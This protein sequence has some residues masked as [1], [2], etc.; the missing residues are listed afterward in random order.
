MTLTI[1]AMDNE[2]NFIRF[3]D[4]ELCEISETHEKGGL[5]TLHL[6]YLFQD[7]NEDRELFQIGNKIWIANDPNLTDCLY[8]I[9]TEVEQDVYKENSFTLD[10]EEVL[11]ELNYAPLFSQTELGL[12]D[13]YNNPVFKLST[14]NG[15]QEVTINW[16]ALNHFFGEYFN[17][18]IVQKC[19]SEYAGKCAINGTMNRMSLLRY[20]EN[21]TGNVFVTRYEKDILTNTIHRYLDFLNPINSNK[22]WEYNIEYDFVSTDTSAEG[23]FDDNDNPTTD[24]Y[25]D[26]EDEDDIVTFDK[27]GHLTNIDPEGISFRFTDNGKI[28]TADDG[29]SLE[30]FSSELGFENNNQHAII[31]ICKTGKTLGLDINEKSYAV[32]DNSQGEPEG[33]GF[34]IVA[35]DPDEPK[36]TLLPD[37]CCFEIYDINQDK[38]I[39]STIINSQIGVVHEEVIDF[40]FNMENVVYNINETDSFNAISPVLSLSEN[41]LSRT[42]LGSLITDWRN[43]SISKGQVIPMIVQKANIKASSLAN[44]KSSLGSYNLSSNYWVRPYNPQDNKD[45][46]SS[47]DYTWEFYRATAYWRAPYSKKSGSLYVE[48][49]KNP[50]QYNTILHRPDSRNTRGKIYTPKM[51]TTESSDENI[52]AIFN[53]VALYLKEHE[54]PSIDIS[55]D[56]ANLQG[57]EFNNYEIHDKV[58]IK[59]PDSQ[60]LVTAR[61]TKTDK[62]ANNVTQN[63]IQLSNYS[64][65][66]VKTLQND[67]FIECAN[68]SFKYP[69]SKTIT[70]R[71][72]NADYDPNDEYRNVEFPANR[73]LTFTVYD[74]NSV[75][76]IYNKL[77]DARGYAKISVKLDPGDYNIVVSFGGDEEYF[78]TEV[79]IDVNVSGTKK[80]ENK[81]SSSSSKQKTTKKT[82]NKTKKVQKY[83]NKYGLSPNKKTILGIGKR[84]ATNDPGS[85]K[86][87]YRTEFKNKCPHC[88]KAEL[89]WSIFW[90]GNET[91]NWGKFP[92]TGRHEG[93]SA[94]GHIFCKSC[95]ADYS[96]FGWEHTS[97]PKKLTIVTKTKKSTKADAYK[98][99]KGK[100][101]YGEI[102]KS[103]KSRNN[104]SDKSRVQKASHISPT[105]REQA[106]KI[107]GNSV[108]WAAAKKIAA[109]TDK[110]LKYHGYTNFHRS[111]KSVL[112][113]GGGNCC[114]VTRCFLE[115]CDAAGCTEYMKLY[116]VHV[117]GHVY[118]RV[119]RKDNGKWA[120]VDCASNY[121]CAWGYVCQGYAHGSPTSE[122]PNLPF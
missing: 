106:L 93:G 18:G 110:H 46:S 111:A 44:A 16:N 107:V 33:N 20:L 94:E 81:T 79:T 12:K 13:S 64:T 7:F 41:S 112:L 68:A 29:T 95:D 15:K 53:Q 27:Y 77:T 102:V 91:S 6:T 113:N 103:N 80:V 54:S 89:Y 74:Q 108:G 104:G 3:L 83:Y 99:K 73:L 39:F 9:N 35:S 84:S 100:M 116:Y 37:G 52:Y 21:E 19:I 57:I 26:V 63:K 72:I 47:S 97:N 121:H 117:Y 96:I 87:F 45:A 23:V 61:V 120:Y 31:S 36:D 8:V 1:V 118:A 71:L 42:Q 49:E 22:D 38:V 86:Y 32:G 10:A 60:E 66:T 69:N 17:I 98:L 25:D 30:W 115:M 5:R 114:D 119:K 76:K 51:G 67:T 65:N 28:L 50:N 34:M 85:D 14:T 40:G 109:W 105:V 82:T 4:P 122:Y 59:L 56:V 24:T 92:A 48:S 88:G 55:V 90:A 58:Y 2:E 78:E 11:V 62:N 43:L 70:A 75:A 101:E